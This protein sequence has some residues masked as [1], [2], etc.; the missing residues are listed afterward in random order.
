M[1]N[2]YV[3]DTHALLWFLAGSQRLSEPA[4]EIFRAGQ[5]GNALVYVP[6]IAVAEIVWVIRANRIR[7]DVKQVLDTIHSNYE[8][9]PLV[10]DDITHLTE[11][12]DQLEMHDRLIVWE[13]MKRQ[14]T[15]ITRDEVICAAKV[16]PTI[17]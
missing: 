1:D 17:W 12:P 8:V 3:A 6:V 13:T 10:F 14:A 11:L 4:R 15:L 16:V 5:A 2:I 7:A 9:V